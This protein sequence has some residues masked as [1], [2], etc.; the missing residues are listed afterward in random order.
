MAISFEST[1]QRNIPFVS[2]EVN[3]AAASQG[4][5]LLAY[6]ALI[7]GQK[8]TGAAAADTLVQ[9]TSVEEVIAQAGRGSMLHRQAVGW[10]ASN[11]S[12]E[13]WLGVLADD[14]GGT[15]ATHTITVT[16]TATES[17]TIALYIGGQRITVA[18]TSGDV[19]NDIAAAIDTAAT[20]ALD[21]PVTSAAATNVVTLTARNAGEVGNE[22]D[23]RDSVAQT[24]SL[25]AG[26]TLAYAA[27]VTGAGNP[28]LTSLIAAMGD[29]WFN[30]IAHPYTDATN[31]TA[32]ETELSDRAGPV[33]QIPGSA[34]TA[35]ADTFANLS[36]LG[37]GRNSEFNSIVAPPGEA[38]LTPSMEF[39]AEVAGIVAFHGQIDPARPF[40]YRALRHTRPIPLGDEF[41]GQER[42]LLLGDGIATVIVGAGQV[43]QLER[44]VTTYQ[45][46]AAGAADT[47]FQD[48]NTL[49]TLMFLRFDLR[50]RVQLAYPNHKLVD[51]DARIGPGQAIVSPRSIKGLAQ[52]WFT[53]NEERGLVENRD[54]FLSGLVVERNA[55]N[56]N[57]I[58]ILVTPNLVNQARQFATSLKFQL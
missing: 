34:F 17:G 21:L 43:V 57:R 5:G 38:P 41:T 36:S 31:L 19:Q 42:D 48:V 13:V 25:P 49:L 18:V 6:R 14:G 24:E 54:A 1:P 32:L 44:M 12:T 33:R 46:N 47:A 7:I 58:D 39:A 8:T 29:I 51:D 9:V 20:A 30:I 15:D 10:F 53:Q 3:A 23:L 2:V 56:P 52:R 16:G 50:T 28:A 40:Q 35:V 37:N 26:V 22:L 4:P 11:S 45:T 27:G 55:T